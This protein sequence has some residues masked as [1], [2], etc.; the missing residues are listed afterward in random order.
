M[1]SSNFFPPRLRAKLAF[2]VRRFARDCRGVTAIEF[3]LV[4]LPFFA[5]VF[6]MMTIGLNYLTYYSLEKGV[7]DAARL[8]RTGE[9]QKAGLD[10]DDFRKLVCDGAGGF[11]TCDNHLVVHI[12]SSETFAGLSPP[13][14]CVT[15]GALSPSSGTGSDALTSKTGEDDIAVQV[16]ACYEWEMGADLWQTIWS[17][18]S[19][20]PVVQGKTI[21]SATTA[22]RSEPYK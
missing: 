6:A 13:A 5:M 8:L 10:L 14:S 3:G 17:L 18:V 22:F 16:T 12:K 2:A 4:A 19:P 1:R 7:V 11:I 20:D 9:A 15:N 21:L